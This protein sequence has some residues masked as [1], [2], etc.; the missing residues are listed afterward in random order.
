MSSNCGYSKV[1]QIEGNEVVCFAGDCGGQDVSVLGMVPHSA[2]QR[3]IVLHRR[4]REVLAHRDLPIARFLRRLRE[5]T[6]QR[7]RDFGE[8]IV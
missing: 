8:G 2:D 7:A 6:D 4:M 1:S 3:L 5:P